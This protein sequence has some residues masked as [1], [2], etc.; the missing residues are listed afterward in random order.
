MNELEI[1]SATELSEFQLTEDFATSSVHYFCKWG[2]PHIFLYFEMGRTRESISAEAR[3]IVYQ[4]FTITFWLIPTF[5]DILRIT[6][7]ARIGMW[8]FAILRI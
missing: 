5:L 2:A 1:S 6:I 4:K 8:S 3:P 7:P